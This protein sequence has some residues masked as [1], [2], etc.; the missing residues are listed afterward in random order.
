M[1]KLLCPNGQPCPE[2]VG[3]IRPRYRDG[4]HFEDDTAGWVAGQIM[5]QVIAAGPGSGVHS[6]GAPAAS[7]N[8]SVGSR[9]G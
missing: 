1:D 6:F 8:A 5:P 4:N 2:S 3:G 9:A 7:I